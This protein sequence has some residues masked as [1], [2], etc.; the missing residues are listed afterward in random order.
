MFMIVR[1]DCNEIKVFNLHI[2]RPCIPEIVKH[3]LS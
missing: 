1:L 2:S 3:D